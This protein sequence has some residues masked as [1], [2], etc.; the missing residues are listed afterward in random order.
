MDHCIYD[1]RVEG[2]NAVERRLVASPPPN[3]D[4]RVVLEAMRAARFSLL[5]IEG[6]EPGVG[7]RVIDLMRDESLFVVDVGFSRSATVGMLLATRLVRLEEGAYLTTGAALP[8]GVLPPAIRTSF[9]ELF[10]KTLPTADFKNLTRAEESQLA[11]NV[12]RSC[13]QTGASERIRYV[14]PRG[15]RAQP[16]SRRIAH[17]GGKKRRRK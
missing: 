10:R 9:V 13:L 14:D 3:D 16:Q 7:V 17:K 8:L 4:E 1:V 2:A 12:I 11:T 15:G 5:A 6:T